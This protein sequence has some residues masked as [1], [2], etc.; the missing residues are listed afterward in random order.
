MRK[1]YL[2]TMAALV[3]GGLLAYGAANAASPAK[4]Q[5]D[6]AKAAAPASSSLS[7]DTVIAKING[8]P[9]KGAE[10]LEM[11]NGM[12]PPSNM[13]PIE[14][15]YDQL[16]D[17]LIDSKLVLDA[18][19]KAKMADDKEVKER[20]R[21]AEER[22]MQDVYLTRE[23]GQKITPAIVEARY[24]KMSGEF[25]PQTEMKA[26]H[27][28]VET[29][30]QAKDIAARL[31]GGADFA[32]LAKEKSIDKSSAENGGDIGFFS[33]DQVVEPFAKTAFA[34]KD[35]EI[36]APVQSQF[37][38]HI[39]Q[40]VSRRDSKMP[41][42]EEVKADVQ[43]IIAEEM[44]KDMFAKLRESAK[45]EKFAMDGK[46]AA[47]APVATPA[48]AATPAAPAPKTVQ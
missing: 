12:R 42:L 11:K 2:Y 30:A 35:G 27:I 28:L 36:S 46:P 3:A 22:I 21:K 16:L 41:P 7:P 1:S 8:Q 10:L 14:M 48:P 6:A 47:A 40:A 4:A 45:V 44:L 38:W 5:P 37:G 25:K 43:Q 32:A 24:K 20:V 15:V 39:I 29:E 13:M 34:L 23:V 19:K 31:K 17:R 18:S 9:I 33:Q 26:R